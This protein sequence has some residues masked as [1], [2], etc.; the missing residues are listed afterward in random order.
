MRQRDV[1]S[2]RRRARTPGP[3]AR[4]VLVATVLTLVVALPRADAKLTATT[5]NGSD[6]WSI[7]TLSAPDPLT[8]AWTGTNSLSLAWTNTS[9]TLPAGYTYERSNSSGSGYATLGT[10]SGSGSVTATDSNPVPPTLRY[11]RVMTTNSSWTSPYT[12]VS[13]SNSCD[14]TITSL[15]ASGTVSGPLGIA[16]DSTGNVYTSDTNGARVIKTTPAGA[17]TTFAGTGVAGYSG[18]GGAASA[19][20]LSL[21]LGLAFDASGNLYIA[22][23]DNYR[24]RKVSTAGIISTIAGTGVSGYTGDGGAATSATMADPTALAFDAS[25]NLYIA[26]AGNNA[27]RKVTSGGTMSTFAG[28]G[29]AGYSGDGGAATSAK[30]AGPYGVIADNA[31]TVYIADSGNGVLRKVTSGTISTIAGGGASSACTF[32]GSATAVSLN[33]PRRLAYDASTGRVFIADRFNH[34]VRAYTAGT[35]S[36]VAGTGTL[37]YTGDNGPAVGATLNEPAGLALSSSGDLYITEVANNV[38]RKILQ[39]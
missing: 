7:G 17:T 16:V 34:C 18:D 3:A 20:K 11:Y 39:A 5:V 1:T 30:L 8:C 25:G 19:A 36:R 37:G 35:I 15:F 33:G 21:P 9:G 4:L 28:T 6:T 24:I 38:V 14:G 22:D 13:A 27:V 32:A 26:E 2:T 29:V 10:T 23:H 12:A 31:G